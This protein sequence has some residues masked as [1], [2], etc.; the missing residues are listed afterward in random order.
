M[1]EGYEDKKKRHEKRERSRKKKM[2][3]RGE[4]THV[5]KDTELG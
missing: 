1:V 2:G 5:Q 3:L 4:V